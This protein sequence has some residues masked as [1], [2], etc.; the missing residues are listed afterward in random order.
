MLYAFMAG[1]GQVVWFGY[2]CSASIEKCGGK[3]KYTRSE[4]PNTKVNIK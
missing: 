3:F 1:A 4:M 2:L